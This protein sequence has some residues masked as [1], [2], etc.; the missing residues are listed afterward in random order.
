M[1]AGYNTLGRE[2]FHTRAAK[3]KTKIQPWAISSN[4]LDYPEENRLKLGE[5]EGHSIER[6]AD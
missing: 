6:H 5:Q 1:P 4:L 2:G 3:C